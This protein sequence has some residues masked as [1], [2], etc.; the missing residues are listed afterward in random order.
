MQTIP[1]TCRTEAY[2]LFAA[3]IRRLETTDGLLKAAIAVSMHA[4]DDVHPD[5]I[6]CRLLALASR[7][8]SRVRGNQIDALLAHLHHVL[9]EEEGFGGN[10]RDYYHPLNSFLPAVLESREGIPVTLSLVYKVVA[11][12]LG[13]TVEGVNSPGHFLARV[14]TDRGAMIVDPFFRGTV[15]T[16]AEAFTRIEYMSRRQI[17]RSPHNLPTATHRQWISRILE[18]LQQIY[19][20]NCRF[21]DLAAMNELQSL[22]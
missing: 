9:F 10:L 11:E 16:E 6:D 1:L 2:D 5:D 12:H 19:V 4:F 21:E 13:L 14:R 7:V 3:Q 22:L 18:N 8:R 20:D 15:L 17:P